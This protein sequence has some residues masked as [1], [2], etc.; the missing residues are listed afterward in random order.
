[1]NDARVNKLNNLTILITF[2]E[3]GF[4]CDC[5]NLFFSYY[6]KHSACVVTRDEWSLLG[7]F[8]CHLFPYFTLVEYHAVL[9]CRR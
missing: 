1:M 9:L 2:S 7:V 8:A 4:F 5:S 6:L 3:T